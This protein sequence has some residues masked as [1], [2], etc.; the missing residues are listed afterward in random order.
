MRKLRKMRKLIFAKDQWKI[1]QELCESGYPKE[2][3]GLLFGEK[4]VQAN[5]NH[6]SARKIVKVV[7]L[8]N[9]LDG[10]HSARLKELMELKALS[11]EPERA[12][13]GGKT[14]FVM[15]PAEHYKKVLEAEKEGL[16]QIGIFHS[17]PDHPSHPSITDASQPFL[18]GWSNVI[19]SVQQ[20]KFAG[21]Q[22]W[23]RE[24]EDSSFQE[25]EI[26]VE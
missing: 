3:C 4:V 12:L 7:P 22:S 1:L 13:A 11:L 23:Y 10:N 8:S 15:D 5:Q 18:A 24:S 19:A 17:H 2:V 21:A 26:V 25:E 20:R 9:V 16:D 14:E 6:S